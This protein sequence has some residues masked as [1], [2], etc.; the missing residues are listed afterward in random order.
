MKIEE[1]L[2]IESK[3]YE[4][5]VYRENA[6]VSRKVELPSTVPESIKISG[7]PLSLDDSSIQIR[8]ASSDILLS[9][10][11]FRVLLEVLTPDK[12]LPAPDNKQL[13]KLSQIRIK[14]NSQIQMVNKLLSR[15]NSITFQ[16]RGIP[17][18]TLIPNTAPIDSRKL[19][20]EFSLDRKHKLLNRLKELRIKINEIDRDIDILADEFSRESTNR[21]NRENELRKSVIINL[22][23]SGKIGEKAELFLEYLTPGARWFP[24]YKLDISSDYSKYLLTLRAMIQQ[25]T[26]ED[27]NNIQI[28]LSTA[29][30]VR[31][32]ELP[33]LSSRIFGR[34]KP[35]LPS[36]GWRKAAE[37]AS[38]LFSDYDKFINKLSQK[39]NA[40]ITKVYAVSGDMEFDDA[41]NVFGAE[42]GLYEENYCDY[43]KEMDM[44][45]EMPMV[46]N[47]TEIQKPKMSKKLRASA[48]VM[49][50]DKISMESLSIPNNIPEKLLVD[51]DDYLPGTELLEYNKMRL[52][53]AE[54]A[55]R[56][57]LKKAP[58]HKL[59]QVSG[60]KVD[61]VY[62]SID[63]ALECTS[64]S[65]PVNCSKPES[66]DG[67]DFSFKTDSNIDI[68]S[69]GS[70]H[71]RSLSSYESTG[72][73]HYI[74]V[75]RESSDVYRFIQFTNPLD[76]PVLTGSIDISIGSDYI[77]TS[78]IDTVPPGGVIKLG[79]GVEEGIKISRNTFFNEETTGLIKG[80]LGLNHKI[81]IVV[82]NNLRTSAEI[83]IRERISVPPDNKSEKDEKV[84]VMIL[85]LK[86]EWEDY[87]QDPNL[88]NGAYRW[89]ASVSPGGKS[90]FHVQ[91]EI[92]IPSPFEIVGGNRREN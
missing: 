73:M 83:E 8:I 67:F 32:M 21:Q 90:R 54:S 45:D 27:W 26:G 64:G 33:K 51:S 47:L 36:S 76:A 59:Y 29:D 23:S 89:K 34:P 46:S 19:L 50:K 66:Y 9:A 17:A 61:I 30:A 53:S 86:P 48:S 49:R 2:K 18:D 68:P 62:K 44:E 91:Y 6:L 84:K 43:E 63:T 11:D 41:D 22:N 38:V 82:Q 78:Q 75:P 58:A 5:T 35:I 3:I 56:G 79:L 72:K 28:N 57:K 15:T 42:D 87:D 70:Y 14:I 92:R 81:D 39:K 52:D 10:T 7:L 13:V 55:T 60:S 31:W 12:E 74:S 4:V 77:L 85:E 88:I 25:H 1:P 24:V 80:N 40:S 69:D 65:V 20:L 37:G 71:I 16:S